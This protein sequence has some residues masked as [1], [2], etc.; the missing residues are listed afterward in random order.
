MGSGVVTRSYG[1]GSAHD[2]YPAM[3][4]MVRDIE[5]DWAEVDL[6]LDELDRLRAAVEAAE[7]LARLV[8]HSVGSEVGKELYDAALAC[9]AAIADP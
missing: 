9:R 6:A 3:V 4:R 7:A 5:P 2:D 8:L 1:T